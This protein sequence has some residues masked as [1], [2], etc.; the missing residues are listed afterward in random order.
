MA[1]SK[2]GKV[3]IV[4]AVTLPILFIVATVVN[5]FVYPFSST[6]P[7]FADVEAVYNKMV[8]PDTWVKKA[9]GSNRGIAGRQC[10]IESDGCFSKVATFSIPAA[11]YTT[12][13]ES[14]AMSMGCPSSNQ[15]RVE[16][17]GGPA[18]MS[19]R[20]ASGAIIVSGTI[21]ERGDNWE[22]YVYSSSR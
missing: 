16:Q 8:V 11:N 1:M 21:I 20:C 12:E 22:A 9:E 6:K 19:F 15:S 2:I 3:F 13:I 14:V 4:V 17:I 5:W 18:S 10:P 7:N